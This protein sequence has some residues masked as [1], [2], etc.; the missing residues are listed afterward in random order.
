[1][2]KD[3]VKFITLRKRSKAL[4]KDTH[5]IEESEWKKIRLNIPKRKHK[6]CFAHESM[7][8]LPK[9]EREIRQ[10]IIK[11]HGRAEPT[12]VI[13]NQKDLPLKTVLEVY[14]K[15]W[16]I[17]NKIAE[18]VAFFNLNALSSPLMVRI[19]FDLLWTIIAD[20]LYHRFAQDLPRF[21]H[22]RAETLFRKFVDMPGKVVFDGNQFVV[23]IRKRACTPILLGVD[24]LNKEIIVPWL[25]GRRLKVEWTA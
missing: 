20:T 1:M 12:F 23:K 3:D 24:L 21:E 8:K 16:R 6:S 13:T 18:M 17:E 10:I 2:A 25:G 5:T 14:A 4:L 11:D 19:H 15:R 22:C 7:I 9:C